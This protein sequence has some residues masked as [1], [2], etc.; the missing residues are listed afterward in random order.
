MPPK[1]AIATAY[2]LP[3]EVTLSPPPLF[4]SGQSVEV[5]ARLQRGAEP[6]V[7]TALDALL[8]PFSFL[9]PCGALAGDSIEPWNSD[10]ADTNLVSTTDDELVWRL[11]G[12]RVD[13]RA[14]VILAQLVLLTQEQHPLEKLSFTRVG[15]SRPRA[16]LAHAKSKGAQSSYPGRWPKLPFDLELPEEIMDTLAVTITLAAPLDENQAPNVEN[17]LLTWAAL[18]SMGAYGVAPVPPAKCSIS[19]EQSLS[20]DGPE[21]SWSIEDFRAHPAALDGLINVLVAIDHDVARIDSV[22]IE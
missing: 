14:A 16:R 15:D 5:R 17:D 1:P 6:Q 20:V 3:F 18:A 7:I 4:S 10:I 21:L 11:D 12:C 22:S 13:E 9:G 2:A 19:P 8:T